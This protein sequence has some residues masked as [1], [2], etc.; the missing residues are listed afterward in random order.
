[1]SAVRDMPADFAER[2]ATTSKHRLMLIYSCGHATLLRW[3][4]QHEGRW[5]K[6]DPHPLRPCPE[7]FA[8][9]ARETNAELIS[10]Y[11]CTSR[12]IMRWREQVGIEPRNNDPSPMPE[13][14][15]DAARRLTTEQLCER[16]GRSEWCIGRWR[17]EAG[18]KPLRQARTFDFSGMTGNKLSVASQ[19]HQRDMTIAGQAADHLR[20]FAPVIRCNE[21]GHYD[22]TGHFWRRGSSTPLSAAEII[23]RAERQGFR[24][25]AWREVR[26]A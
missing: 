20:R 24:P 3:I 15:T 2:F 5:V 9:H 13:G 4:A 25:D 10:R 1:M 19:H 14:F 26:A 16:F 22:P 21:Q 11:R 7:D 8:D 6:A 12:T 23:A 17:R 18:I